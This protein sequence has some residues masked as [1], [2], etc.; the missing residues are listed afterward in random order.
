MNIEVKKGFT[1]VEIMVEGR[2]DTVTA[3]ELE[4]CLKVQYD[5]ITELVFDFSKLEYISS[6]GLRVL[7]GAQK[8]MNKIGTMKVKNVNPT[9]MEVFE[10]TGFN[11]ILNIE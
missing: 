10:I 2:L 4:A 7:L 1:D 9:V 8:V 5:T 6:A 11:D 3:P